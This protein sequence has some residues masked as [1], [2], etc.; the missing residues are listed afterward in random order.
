MNG[1]WRFSLLEDVACPISLDCLNFGV[2]TTYHLPFVKHNNENNKWW[3]MATIF[4]NILPPWSKQINQ[5][6]FPLLLIL[7]FSDPNGFYYRFP[8]DMSKCM[9]IAGDTIVH[10]PL[11]LL[12][13]H[14]FQQLYLT[15]YFIC[16]LFCYYI[17]WYSVSF[18]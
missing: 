16:L 10:L 8:P 3:K 17:T 2:K 12:L 18:D 11:L 7:L 1:F 15:V 4:L 9:Y 6:P 5:P 13:Q 14:I